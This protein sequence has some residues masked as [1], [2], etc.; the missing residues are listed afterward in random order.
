MWGNAKKH[1]AAKI[2]TV[3]GQHT[4]IKGDVHF[5]G[6]L[7][8]DGKVKGNVLA[9]ASGDSVLT[10]SEQGS[11]EGEVRVPDVIL[12][13]VVVGDVYAT[14]RIELAAHARVKGNV[15]YKLIEMAMGAE[16]NGNLVHRGQEVAQPV[17]KAVES[18]VETTPASPSVA[19][20][21]KVRTAE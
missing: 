8:V 5:T 4:V 9:D 6:G 20:P 15:F 3:I 12:N 13:G 10:L 16:V 1:T 7:H 17:R 11:I 14:E 2:D 18:K 21:H 19:A